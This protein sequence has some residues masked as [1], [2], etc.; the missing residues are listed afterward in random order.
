MSVSVSVSG[1]IP[2]NSHF[3]V[4]VSVSCLFGPKDAEPSQLVQCQVLFLAT[5]NLNYPPFFNYY[6]HI[7][8]FSN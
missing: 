1:L 3:D 5:P 7:L 2:Q 4:A 6:I 8:N